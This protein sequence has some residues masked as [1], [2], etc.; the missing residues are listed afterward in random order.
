MSV[1]RVNPRALAEYREK[2]R[3]WDARTYENIKNDP[4]RY[5]RR[6]EKARGADHRRRAEEEDDHRSLRL[7]RKAAG[8]ANR[9]ARWSPDKRESTNGA[10]RVAVKYAGETEAE[11]E[12]RV[13]P[14][15]VKED[16]TPEE[17]EAR[18]AKRKEAAGRALV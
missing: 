4:A 10:R 16:E 2:V 1:L 5:G 11:R 15:R 14:R 8:E 9:R 17:A 18:K 3:I 6:L 13:A 12:A 7:K